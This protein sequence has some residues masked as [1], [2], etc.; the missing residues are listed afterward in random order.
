MRGANDYGPVAHLYDHYVQ[1]DL[2][3]DFFRR[4]VEGAAGPVLELMA[5]TGRVSRGIVEVAGNLTCLDISLSMLRVLKQKS[6]GKSLLQVVCGDVR[7]LPLRR[8][9]HLVI[10]PFNSFSELT[11]QAE[12]RKALME[13]NRV[14]IPGGRCIITLHNPVVRARA[15]EQGSR[16]VAAH[17]LPGKEGRLEVWIEESP[18]PASHTVEC[19]QTFLVYAEDGELKHRHEMDLRYSLI[20]KAEFAALAASAGFEVVELFGDYDRQIFEPAASPF[21]IWVL[22]SWRSAA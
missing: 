6:T 22:R 19:V 15:F 13:I 3:L 18:D 1:T 8:R 12:Q 9:F 21:M 7:R 2:D 16:L 5:G 17:D 20:E 11:E 4:E 10:I 14:L